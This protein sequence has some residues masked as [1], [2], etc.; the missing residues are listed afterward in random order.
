MWTL[1]LVSK[2]HRDI[3]GAWWE[4]HQDCKGTKIEL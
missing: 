3:V 4:H 1:D 2:L